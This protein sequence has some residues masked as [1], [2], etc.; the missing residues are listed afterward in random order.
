LFKESLLSHNLILRPSLTNGG[1]IRAEF[2]SALTISVS[3]R[4]LL[5]LDLTV[6]YEHGLVFK[7]LDDWRTSVGASLGVRF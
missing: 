4:L 5:R 3:R 1:D 7:E 6:D 2:E